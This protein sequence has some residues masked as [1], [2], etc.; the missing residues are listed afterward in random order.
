MLSPTRTIAAMRDPALDEAEDRLMNGRPGRWSPE[1]RA[2]RR[3]S[4]RVDAAMRATFVGELGEDRARVLLALARGDLAASDGG[5]G[6]DA[7]DA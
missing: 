4:A 3:L 2:W 5:D 1:A 7:A 6:N